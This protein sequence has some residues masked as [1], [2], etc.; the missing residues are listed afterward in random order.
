LIQI[1]RPK[2]WYIEKMEKIAI[3]LIKIEKYNSPTDKLGWKNIE[4]MLKK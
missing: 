3:D 1:V 2:N 4:E